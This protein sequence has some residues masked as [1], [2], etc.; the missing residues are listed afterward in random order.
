MKHMLTPEEPGSPVVLHSFHFNGFG[1]GKSYELIHTRLC[2][3]GQGEENLEVR[4]LLVIL[5]YALDTTSFHILNTQETV[6]VLV[7][8]PAYLGVHRKKYGVSRIRKG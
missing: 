3:A 8:Q 6:S 2:T 4:C 5:L 7:A 1:F